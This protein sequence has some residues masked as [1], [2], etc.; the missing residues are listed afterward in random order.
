M[1]DEKIVDFLKR[2]K[3]VFFEKHKNLSLS[4]S[5][6]EGKIL[7]TDEIMPTCRNDYLHSNEFYIDFLKKIEVDNNGNIFIYI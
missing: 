1:T 5:D 3:D 4:K 2:I 6:Y 7:K